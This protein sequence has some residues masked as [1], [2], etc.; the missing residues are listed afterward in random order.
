MRCLPLVLIVVSLSIS[1]ASSAGSA[2]RFQRD[3]MFACLDAASEATI[4]DCFELIHKACEHR[5]NGSQLDLYNS[6]LNRL[7]KIWSHAVA[8]QLER[9]E[10]TYSQIEI[11]AIR[12]ALQARREENTEICYDLIDWPE[13]DS[14]HLKNSKEF[15]CRTVANVF[16]SFDLEKSHDGLV[17]LGMQSD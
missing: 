5:W 8:R 4:G 16:A 6:C 7:R 17:R 2:Y 15:Y 1:A 9:L 14:P 11:D 12:R 3:E 10:Q 13:V